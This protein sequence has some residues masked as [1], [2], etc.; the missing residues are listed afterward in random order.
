ME[1]KKDSRSFFTE[2]WRGLLAGSLAALGGVLLYKRFFR[3]K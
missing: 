2:H 3:Q 1:A